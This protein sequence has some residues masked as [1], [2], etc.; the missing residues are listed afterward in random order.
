MN[1]SPHVGEEIS[2][3]KSDVMLREKNSE[4][5]FTDKLRFI[6]LNLPY[7]TKKAEECVTDFEKWIY[8]LKH[9]T[10]LERIP[11]ETQKK[12]F[13]RLAEVADSRCLS[14]EEMEKY[15][16]SQRQVDNY[17]LGMYSA[18]LEGNEKGIKQGIE[19]GIEQGKELGREER[20][21][22][23]A[24]MMIQEREPVE[25]IERYTGYALEKLKEISNGIGI[26]LMK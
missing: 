19:Q 11:F 21:I 22:S 25:K 17:N 9:M 24:Q 26:P 13:K 2:Q 14:K 10:T 12:I 1:F 4:V 7:F 15:E 8:V 20:N 5:P 16:E 23:M 18:W 3:F 6:Y